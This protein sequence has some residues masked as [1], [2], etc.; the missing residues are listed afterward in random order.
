M[1]DLQKSQNTSLPNF[2]CADDPPRLNCPILSGELEADVD[3]TTGERICP[4]CRV[5]FGFP[6]ELSD[7]FFDDDEDDPEGEHGDEFTF[8]AEGDKIQAWTPEKKRL[9]GRKKIMAGKMEIIVKHDLD[10]AVYANS[11]ENMDNALTTLDKLEESEH[12]AFVKGTSVTIKV[13][14]ILSHQRGKLPNQ[15]CLEA[16][17]IKNKSV[18]DLVKQLDILERPDI[19][20]GVSREID[21]LSR[22][23]D[24]IPS[25][26]SLQA[27]ESYERIRPINSVLSE[28]VI[29]AAWLYMT[30]KAS[31][32]K[33][34]KKDFH[35]LPG[36]SR[37]AFN[38]SIINYEKQGNTYIEEDVS[39]EI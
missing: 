28:K 37:K 15:G 32:V 38:K 36:V 20:S 25:T 18:Y 1:S 30:A 12:P 24:N 11:G 5:S 35:A 39:D 7:S 27:R 16:L 31:N 8:I 26:I 3:T 17:N 13:I 22:L 33:V 34:Y 6:L 2:E 10:F 19:R 21:L 4:A 23:I 29:A 14:A 9:E